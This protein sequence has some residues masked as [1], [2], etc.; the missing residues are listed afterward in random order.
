[1]AAGWY[2]FEWDQGLWI[3]S[4]EKCEKAIQLTYECLV[5]LLLTKIMHG[6][7]SGYSSFSTRF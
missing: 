4:G 2:G 7:T 1:M 3:L 6:G 5:V